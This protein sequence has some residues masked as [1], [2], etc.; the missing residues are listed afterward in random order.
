MG[1][2]ACFVNHVFHVARRE[3]LSFFDIDRLA[4]LRNGA[5]EIGLTAQK[6]RCLQ[7][8]N[9]GCNLSNLVFA[10]D[11]CQDRQAEFVF[12]FC[13][14]LQPFIDAGTAKSAT[15]GAVGFVKTAFENKGNTETVGD[16]FERASSVHLQL[17]GLDHAGAGNQE[18]RLL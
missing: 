11:V 15:A 4:A 3:K 8:V 7:D 9:D 14:N 5:D 1:R 18:K 12:D 2:S 17:F 10:V 16:F 6:G 13:Q